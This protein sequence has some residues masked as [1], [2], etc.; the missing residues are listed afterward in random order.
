MT[1]PMQD[2]QPV[3]LSSQA[4][5]ILCRMYDGCYDELRQN[6]QLA[7]LVESIA[8][9]LLAGVETLEKQEQKPKNITFPLTVQ[10]SL[11]LRRLVVELLAHAP[12]NGEDRTTEWLQE[13]LISLSGYGGANDAP[14][15]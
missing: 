12:A 11:F 9:M 8:N 13:C 5:L 4:F 15:S 7:E 3:T 14:R 2:V 1:E 6:E 10:Q